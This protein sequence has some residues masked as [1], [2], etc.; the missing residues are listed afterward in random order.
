MLGLPNSRALVQKDLWKLDD[1]TNR[2]LIKLE[3][4]RCEVL[5]LEQDHP[6]H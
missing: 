4:G 2:N 1:W 6:M 3:E 5:H